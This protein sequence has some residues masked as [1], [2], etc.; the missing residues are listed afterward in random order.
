MQIVGLGLDIVGALLI[1][2]TAWLRI[3][4]NM[5]WDDPN[6]PKEGLRVRRRLV[7]LGGLLLTVG[8]GLQIWGTWL[9][10]P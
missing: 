4:M 3:S 1:A 8:F 2:F 9:Q 5:T 10:M 7:I 6:E